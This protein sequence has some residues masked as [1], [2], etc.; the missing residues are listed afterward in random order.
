[1]VRKEIIKL[2]IYKYFSSFLLFGEYEAVLELL[3]FLCKSCYASF[4]FAHRIIWFLKS[5]IGNNQQINDKIRMVLHIIQTVF[6]SDSDKNKIENFYLSGSE[7]YINFIK[8]KG[9]QKIYFNI[10]DSEFTSDDIKQYYEDKKKFRNLISKYADSQYIKEMHKL[11]NNKNI[12][13]L[14]LSQPEE[15]ILEDISDISFS[16]KEISLNLYKG[17]DYVTNDENNIHLQYMKQIDQNDINLTSFLSNT[18]FFDHLC[19]ICDILLNIVESDRKKTLLTEL[20][21]INK[22]LPSNVYIPFVNNSIRNYVI[23]SIPISECHIFKTKTRAPYMIAI[24]CFRL[25]ELNYYLEKKDLIKISP[26]NEKK[27]NGFYRKL[28]DSEIIKD[29]E[30]IGIK[31]I[32]AIKFPNDFEGLKRRKS[33]GADLKEKE[34]TPKIKKKEM[35]FSENDI[36]FSK[37]ITIRNLLKKE[38]EKEIDSQ[39]KEL[40]VLKEKIISPKS[41]NMKISFNFKENSPKNKYNKINENDISY[42]ELSINNY[43]NTERDLNASN[44]TPTK[45]DK[46]ENEIKLNSNLS[47]FSNQSPNSPNSSGSSDPDITEIPK[48]LELENESL[49]NILNQIN[50]ENKNYFGETIEQQ[51]KRLKSLSPFGNLSSYKV[52]NIIIKSGEDLRQEQFATQLI[53]EFLQIFKIEKVKCYLM[54][55]EIIA[56]GVNVGI[57]EVVPNSISIDQIKRKNKNITSLVD[58]YKNYFGPINSKKYKN[59]IQ[60]YIQSLAGYSLLCYFL[61]IK[62]RHNANIMIDSEGHLIHIDFGFM[63]SNAPGKGLKFEKA[64]FKLT[65]DLV[66]VIGGTKSKL[67]DEFRKLLW[68]GFIA[69]VK[70][71]ERILILV[72]MMYCGHGNKLPCFEGG[73]DAINELKKRFIPKNNMKSRDYREHVDELISQSLDNWRSNWYDKFQYYVQGILP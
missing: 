31:N 69:L 61:Q 46:I 48:I 53:N 9:F 56:T 8:K 25:D 32:S 35:Y 72:E 27:N 7:D 45:Y 30:Y 49:S 59:A 22:I 36:K 38:E 39:R 20:K 15:D 66:D 60:N 28:S 12:E 70:H 47:F 13:K 63:L 52:V 58:F 23:A 3:S 54:P 64:P 37:P 29:E 57:V 44:V 50:I 18:N 40:T 62:D 43:Q 11:N 5:S 24:E 16:P 65:N 67:F 33:S 26:K 42:S 73:Q 14:D 4:S 51:T 19:N 21:K 17:Y 41:Q 34:K 10:E 2:Y 1:M 68:K 71:H 55:Y 6:K